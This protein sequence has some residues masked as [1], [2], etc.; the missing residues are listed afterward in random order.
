MVGLLADQVD[1][2]RIR[3][4]R[5]AWPKAV[6]L[7]TFRRAERLAALNPGPETVLDEEDVLVFVA[8]RIADCG[9]PTQRSLLP[10]AAPIAL[11]PPVPERARRVLIL[12]WSRKI[13]SLLR[14]F[15]D[16]GQDAF[17]IDVVTLTRFRSASGCWR[18][19]TSARRTIACS[20]SRPASRCPACSIASSRSDTT[21]SC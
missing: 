15:E 17:E 12:G 19:S 5:G 11:A 1:Q 8:R 6:L 18:S 9:P 4:L 13:P 14:E 21:T 16:Y 10:E 20:I 3:E 2:A 7:G